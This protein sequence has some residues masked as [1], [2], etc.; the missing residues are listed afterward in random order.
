MKLP[1]QRFRPLGKRLL[2][3]RET[4]ELKKGYIFLAPSWVTFGW[5]AK[6]VA[7]GTAAEG[8]QP[9]DNILFLKDATV[10]P[11]EDR[12]MAVT[13]SDKVLAKI[14]VDN[15]V[16][17]IIPQNEYVMLKLD[18]QDDN[19]NMVTSS[20]VPPKNSGTVVKVGGNCRDIKPDMHV[21]FKGKCV[22]CIEDGKQYKLV[23]EQSVICCEKNT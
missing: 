2:I 23:E 21:W 4:P 15:N 6:V 20:Y 19:K 11:F 17:W 9:E 7:V 8:F 12:A 1:E 16:E 5:R 22:D 3:C 13:E 14:V 10:L 18:E